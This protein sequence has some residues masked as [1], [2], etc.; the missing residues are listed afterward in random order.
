LGQSRPGRE[1]ERA[2][3]REHAK[4]LESLLKQRRRRD[5]RAHNKVQ[6]LKVEGP[7]IGDQGSGIKG[8][9]PGYLVLI[10]DA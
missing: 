10:P 6:N 5:T 8:S 2:G 4:H 9:D 3:Q 1:G 7:G